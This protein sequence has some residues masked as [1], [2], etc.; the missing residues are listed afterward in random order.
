MILLLLLAESAKA[1][2]GIKKVL[3]GGKGGE[4][5]QITNNYETITKQ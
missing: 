3:S 2:W 5:S 1:G 4:K